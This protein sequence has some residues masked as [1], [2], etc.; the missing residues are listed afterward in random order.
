MVD[1]I[2]AGGGPAG[3]FLACE[4]R[5]AG[6]RPLVLERLPERDLSDKAH[7]VAGQ[8]V[9]L[10]DHRGLIE[11]CGGQ[12][13]PEPAPGFFYAGIPLPLHVL[14]EDNPVYLRQVNQRDLERVLAERAAELGA[15]VRRGWEVLSFSQNEHQVDVVA[16][17]AD[18]VEETFT[19]RYLVGCDGG[20]SLV[21]K[22]SGI[23]F[24][25]HI[26]KVVDRSALI[27]PSERI[28]KLPMPFHRTE[29]GV[30]VLLPHDPARP[31]VFT[32]EWEDCP[33]PAAPMTLAEMEDSIERVLGERVPLSP[34]PEGS[35]T[36][37]RRLSHRNSRLA[38]RYRDGR[39]F[40]AG[41][42][43]HVSHGPTLNAA[44]GDV[45]NL[46]WKLAAAAQGRAPDGLL[47]SYES[48]RRAVGAR[49]LVHT[50]A[51]TAL[52]APGAGVTALRQVFTELLG[53]KEN[54][55]MIA[56]TMAGA[57]VRYDMGEENPAGPAGWFVPPLTVTTGDGRAHRIAEL[58][59]DARPVLLD[60]TGAVELAEVAQPWS[61]VVRIVPATADDAP[62]PAFLIR[63]DGYVAWAGADPEGLK[64]ALTR[65]IR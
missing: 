30:F 16:R 32:T 6:A 12:G 59:R 19:A 21:R 22:Q 47:D 11:R 1:V 63:P 57:D 36:Q 9:R 60:L 52:T 7:G 46:G 64:A 39:V 25:G 58:L 13:A 27:A 15:E 34:P 24:P 3:L 29:N 38:E 33:D 20:G 28:R 51:E 35:P 18:G 2:I 56:D 26:E 10:L 5:L 23:G 44:L 62:A 41:D 40:L 17:G 4:L 37:L 8:S 45:A 50:Q 14:G 42:A 61:D 55:R 31:H 54:V 65:W 49:V 43:A 48:E 53:R